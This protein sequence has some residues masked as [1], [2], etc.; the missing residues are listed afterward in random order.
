VDGVAGRSNTNELASMIGE[1]LNINPMKVEHVMEGYTGTLGSYVWDVVDIGLRKAS[2]D[3]KKQ[4]PS[5][6][7]YR[8]FPVIKRFFSAPHGA[9]YKQQFYDLSN[10]VNKTIGTMDMLKRNGRIDELKS[11]MHGREDLLAVSK[12]TARMAEKLAKLRRYKEMITTSELTPDEKAKR[13]D[14]IDALTNAMLEQPV[15]RLRE[16]TSLPVKLPFLD[17]VYR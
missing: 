10:E 6:P 3:P 1:A 14:E 17:S 15:A 12:A 11:F 2:G 4:L 16:V 9:G 13:V 8:Q 5:M 7:M